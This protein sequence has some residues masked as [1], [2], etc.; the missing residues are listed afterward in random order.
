MPC[1]VYWYT[2]AA[3]QGN[4]YAQDALA[5]CYFNGTGIRKNKAKAV[6]WWTKAAEEGITTAQ[7]NLG[8]CYANGTGVPIDKKKAAYWWKKAA[9]QYDEQAIEGLKLLKNKTMPK[10]KSVTKTKNC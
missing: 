4:Y 10:K 8:A 3:E 1:S 9:E 7:F 5:V 6:H 2:K